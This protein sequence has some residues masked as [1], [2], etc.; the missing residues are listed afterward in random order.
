M[1]ESINDK[2][3]F[4]A[5]FIIGLPGAGKSYTVKRL[6]GVVSPII[7][8]TDKAS[9]YLGKK[10]GVK[11][12]SQNWKMLEDKTHKMTR[13]SLKNYINGMLPLFIDGTSNDAS[14]ILH[15]MGILESLGYD[16]GIIHVY[17][18]IETAKRRAKERE[19]I[20]GRAVDEDFIEVVNKHSRE[21]A[22]FLKSKVGFF[23]EIQNNSD[24]LD[25]SELEEAFNATQAFFSSPVKNPIGKRAIEDIK[26]GK[27]KYMVPLVVTKEELDNKV[28]GWY[29]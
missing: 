15:R 5:I 12:N 24:R 13:D 17:A 11:V 28:Q 9:E 23:K 14:N 3:I 18:D 4:K 16:V 27:E 22:S 8:N 6:K 1:S 25:D 26:Q 21:N 20:I 19:S 10:L 29:R 7:V 2:G